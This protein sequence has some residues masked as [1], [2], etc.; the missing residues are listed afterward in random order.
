MSNQNIDNKKLVRDLGMETL[1]LAS[2]YK[3]EYITLE[4]ILYVFLQTK[5]V[6]EIYKKHSLDVSRATD[7]LLSL[8]EDDTIF[9]KSRAKP[10]PSFA[11]EQ[12]IAAVIVNFTIGKFGNKF[13]PYIGMLAIFFQLNLEDC[14]AL[15]ALLLSGITP[16]LLT[17]DMTKSY[18]SAHDESTQEA[19]P[20]NIEDAKKY[21]NNYCINLN[22]EVIDG[23][24]DPLI[25]RISEVE[26]MIQI[27]ARR[28]KNNSVLVGQPGV[29]KTSVVE[30]LAYKIV[31]KEVPTL[32]ADKIIYSLD[33]GALVAGTKYRGDFEERMKNVLSSLKLVGNTILFIDEIHMIMEAGSSGKGNMDVANLLKPA[34][35]KGHLRCIGSTTE[36]EFRKCFEKDRALLRRFKKIKIDEPSPELTKQILKGLKS[37]YEKYHNVSYTEEALNA[38]VDLTSKY[39][40]G[41]VLPDKAIDAIDCAGAVAQLAN[42]PIVDVVDIETEISKITKIPKSEVHDNERDKLLKL[43]SNLKLKIFGQDDAVDKITNSIYVSRAGLRNPQKPI[44]SYLMVGPSGS[45]KTETAKVIAETMAIPLVRFDMSEYMEK[46]AVSKLI[47]SPPGYVGFGDGASGSGLLINAIDSSPS[48]VLLLDEIEK[49]HPEL[50]AILLQVM[51]AGKLTAGNGKEVNF[52]NVIILM[53]SNAGAAILEKN[54]IGF[55]TSSTAKSVY[56]EEAVK[57]AFTPEFRNRLDAIIP[58]HKLSP[59]TMIHI[60]D[61]FIS[62]L[63]VLSAEKNVELSLTNSAKQW[64]AEKGYDPNM[65]ARPLHRLITE[66]ISLPLSKMMLFGDLTNGG[67]AEIGLVNDKITIEK[68]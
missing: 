23:R 11:Y 59:E 62:E 24:I 68:I 36:D 27:M 33:I 47:G 29:G 3:H 14:F 19:S 56:N 28:N 50:L 67:K 53:T 65:G 15:N 26:E 34:L 52:R 40:H 57:K 43:E 48:C 32:L 64:L 12:Y 20:Q 1:K 38:A 13:D 22:Q 55:E 30:G 35:A 42:K 39:V 60:V 5:N 18:Q 54:V 6:Q 51:D 37:I 8:F 7:M 45:G 4:H 31:H 44:G 16:E 49:A 58:F 9:E 46:H 61:K 21:L 17:Q 10:I 41:A 66:T 2:L 63:N 25:G